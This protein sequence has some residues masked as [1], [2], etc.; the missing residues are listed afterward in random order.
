MHTYKPDPNSDTNFSHNGD[1]SGQVQISDGQERVYVTMGEVL[2]FVAEYARQTL[3]SRVET[4][5]TEE[6]IRRLTQ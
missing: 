3:V 2:S 1:Y 5:T 6:I 4:M